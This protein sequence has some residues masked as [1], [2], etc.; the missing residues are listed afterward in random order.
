MHRDL[1]CVCY[2]PKLSSYANLELSD[3]VR[4]VGSSIPFSTI[5][6]IVRMFLKSPFANLSESF[7]DDAFVGPTLAFTSCS[8]CGLKFGSAQQL[9]LHRFKAHGVKHPIRTYVNTTHCVV[10]LREF[11][12]RERLINHLRYR[13]RVCHNNIVMRGPVLSHTE[14]DF[15]DDNDKQANVRLSSMGKR[16]HTAS[17]PAVR[18]KGRLLPIILADATGE[19]EHHPF[20]WGHN[21]H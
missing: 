1:Q 7:S 18:L 21:S 13:S 8:D 6:R 15:L 20:G 14:A 11:W 2:E 5:P 19:S 9:A 17:K 10:C 3:W 16:R 4:L 12:V